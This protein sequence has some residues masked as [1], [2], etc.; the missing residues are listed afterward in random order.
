[1][2]LSKNSYISHDNKLLTFFNQYSPVLLTRNKLNMNMVCIYV[3]LKIL[4]F[5]D[6]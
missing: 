3:Q 6:N 5:I 4:S 2:I 1:M